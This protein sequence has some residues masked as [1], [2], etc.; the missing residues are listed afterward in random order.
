MRGNRTY[1]AR[2]TV[3]PII[4]RFSQ[5]GSPTAMYRA[6]G[7]TCRHCAFKITS[8]EE[9]RQEVNSHRRV[10]ARKST[11]QAPRE[12]YRPAT[13]G[14][15]GFS[16]KAPGRTAEQSRSKHLSWE[17]RYTASPKN[18]IHMCPFATSRANPQIST[19]V[20]DAAICDLRTCARLRIP[21]PLQL[22]LL[23]RPS[24]VSSLL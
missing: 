23:F 13:E 24:R 12:R 16:F 4:S 17:I 9:T 2:C 7:P 8:S 19:G 21:S 22:N 6:F 10:A 18:A 3:L 20:A 5:P 1:L 11:S 15:S 14:T